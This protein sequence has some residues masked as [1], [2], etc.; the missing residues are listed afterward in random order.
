[1][2]KPDAILRHF[3]KLQRQGVDFGGL[4]GLRLELPDFDKF[5]E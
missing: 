2:A 5:E 4:F 1:M 3:R